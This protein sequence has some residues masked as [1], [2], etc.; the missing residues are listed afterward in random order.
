MNLQIEKCKQKKKGAKEKQVEVATK[1]L[2]ITTNK[3]RDWK[4][5]EK[6]RLLVE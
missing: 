2:K 5:K 6:Q 3:W 1:R 4:D